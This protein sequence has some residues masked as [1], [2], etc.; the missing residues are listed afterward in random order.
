MFNRQKRSVVDPYTSERERH[1]VCVLRYHEESES[2][3]PLTLF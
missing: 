1:G 2:S 3:E